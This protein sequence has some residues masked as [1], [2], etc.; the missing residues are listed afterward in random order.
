M[1][2]ELRLAL[3]P[4]LGGG[5]LGQ[6]RTLPASARVTDPIASNPA[7]PRPYIPGGDIPTAGSSLGPISLKRPAR[8]EFLSRF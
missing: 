2:D 1:P 8:C 3:Q 7:Q 5:A 6:D 4:W